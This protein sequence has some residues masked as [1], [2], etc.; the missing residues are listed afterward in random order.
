MRNTLC[1]DYCT[2]KVSVC[3]EDRNKLKKVNKNHH[4]IANKTLTRKSIIIFCVRLNP[5]RRQSYFSA[6]LFW[7]LYYATATAAVVVVI[8]F[9]ATVM[10]MPLLLLLLHSSGCWQFFFCSRAHVCV[11]FFFLLRSFHFSFFL[12]AFCDFSSSNSGIA[13]YTPSPSSWPSPP[14]KSMC[15][16][17]FEL[18][19]ATRYAQSHTDR[20]REIG[21]SVNRITVHCELICLHHTRLFFYL[22]IFFSLFFI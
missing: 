14:S 10:L 5:F 11:C 19:S 4:T 3:T 7:W 18:S 12:G 9:V 15:M 22:F 16:R 6:S 13:C 21:E 20:K 8:V 17:F 2:Y 1:L